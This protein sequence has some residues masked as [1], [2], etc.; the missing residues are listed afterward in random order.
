MDSPTRRRLV[1]GFLESAEKN[2]ISAEESSDWMITAAIHSADQL[3]ARRFWFT[4]DV[5][6]PHTED[7]TQSFFAF[8]EKDL[9]VARNTRIHCVNL[10]SESIMIP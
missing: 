3:H 8:S 2:D 10:H 5:Y 6:A 7:E 9:S 4:E 1:V